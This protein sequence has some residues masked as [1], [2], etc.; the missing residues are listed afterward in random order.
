MALAGDATERISLDLL[1][2]GEANKRSITSSLPLSF[3][4]SSK[5]F[6]NAIKTA[7][8]G[9]EAI[10]IRANDDG[11]QFKTESGSKHVTI[12][13]KKGSEGLIEEDYNVPEEGVT[14]YPFRY[15]KDFSKLTKVTEDL[16]IEFATK[17]PL[18]I[19]Y[20]IADGYIT[21]LLAPRIDST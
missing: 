19:T 17:K 6:A 14:T 2:L 8:L 16:M 7:E 10:E 21:Y 20:E 12:D 18:K 9:G 3:R 15:L 1:D 5:V 4:L 11:V 13:L